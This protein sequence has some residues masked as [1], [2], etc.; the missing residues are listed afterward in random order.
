M[1]HIKASGLITLP[2]LMVSL[3]C[4]LSC[5]GTI[6]EEAPDFTDG[7]WVAYSPYK[8]TH[9][10]FPVE[11]KYCKL[12]SDR[13]ERDAREELVEY[14][15][16]Q[17]SDIMSMFNFTAVDDFLYPPGNTKIEVNLS[18][19]NDPDIAAAFWGS[20]LMKVR[21]ERPDTNLLRYVLRH[22]LTHAFEYLIEGTPELGTDVWFREGL[23]VYYASNGSWNSMNSVDNLEA[24]IDDHEEHANKGNPISIHEW[25]DFPEGS[26]IPRYYTLF[27][28][29]IKYIISPD[30]LGKSSVELLNIVYEV[31]EGVLFESAF[32]D[33]V[34]IT[35]IDFESEIFP[36]LLQF[37]DQ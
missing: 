28:L 3:L 20:V 34:Q 25:E 13:V 26:D 2:G 33:Q 9:D 14:A 5:E 37:L 17:F 1:K 15:D 29:V 11:G 30:G 23:A 21:N 24:Y 10:G 7:S 6:E 32:Y 12:Y 8:W 19:D 36:R 4:L 27:D 22:E 16:R 35:L 18:L 31:R